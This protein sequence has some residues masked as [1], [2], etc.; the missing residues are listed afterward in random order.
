[1]PTSQDMHRIV[2]AAPMIQANLFLLLDAL[3]HQHLLCCRRTFLGRQIYDPNFRWAKEPHVED[4]FASSGDFGL[5][6]LLR[7]LIK[8]LEAQGRG[9]A[10]GHEKTHSEPMTKA[11]DLNLAFRGP[12]D[13]GEHSDGRLRAWTK[14]TAP[15]S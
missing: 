13:D 15:L 14:S 7:A 10:H 5:A 4:D 6:A 11:I 1:M 8:A 2:A 3:T 12:G 9:F